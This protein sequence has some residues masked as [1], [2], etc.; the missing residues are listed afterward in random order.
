M[1]TAKWKEPVL[2]CDQT[3]VLCSP[4]HSPVGEQD[5]VRFKDCVL[6]SGLN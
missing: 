6:I 4:A 5:K 2:S 1:M 3:S